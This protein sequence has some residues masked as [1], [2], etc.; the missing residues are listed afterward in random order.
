MHVLHALS[1]IL[2]ERHS[3][4]SGRACVVPGRAYPA[5]KR[6]GICRDPTEEW[7]EP[8]K[9]SWRRIS[10]DRFL[11]QSFSLSC[12]ERLRAVFDDRSGLPG[13]FAATR[14]PCTAVR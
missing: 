10:D 14:D 2:A 5:P 7:I 4:L 8:Y 9:G 3:A 6:C 12:G 1:R 11:R 13:V